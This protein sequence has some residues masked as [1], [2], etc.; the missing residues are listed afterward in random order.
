M[1]LECVK[2][3]NGGSP[4]ASCVVSSETIM[5][6]RNPEHRDYCMWRQMLVKL[7][8]IGGHVNPFGVSLFV[9]FIRKDRRDEASGWIFFFLQHFCDNRMTAWEQIINRKGRSVFRNRLVSADHAW[10]MENVTANVGPLLRQLIA[11]RILASYLAEIYI[12]L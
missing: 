11:F 12:N 3:M 7:V 2:S 1:I 4:L 8:H 6:V 9:C 10:L 5:K